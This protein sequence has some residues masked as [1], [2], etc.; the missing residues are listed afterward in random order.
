VSTDRDSLAALRWAAE[1]IGQEKPGHG[2]D[3]IRHGYVPFACTD[4]CDNRQCPRG[5]THEVC[6]DECEE[7]S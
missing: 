4:H 3:A 7:P 6:T 1:H 5:L 2:P